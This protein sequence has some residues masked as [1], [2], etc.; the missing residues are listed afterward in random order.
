M[1]TIPR[2]L[3]A[4]SLIWIGLFRAEGQF[5]LLPM[6]SFGTAGWL[7]PN[8]VN[9]SSY[10]YL[11][12]NDTE[13]GMACG[14]SRLYLVSRN[15]GNFVRILDGQSGT[16]LGSLNLGTGMVSGGTFDVNAIAVADDGAIYVANLAIGPSAF[17]VYRWANDQPTTTPILVYNGVP[18]AGARLGDSLAVIG[19]GTS[20]LLAGGFNSAPAVSGNNG[21]AIIDPTAESALAVVFS[22]S[23]PAAGDFR[24]GITFLDS[25]HVLGTQGGS[26]LYSSFSGTNGTLLASPGLTSADERPLAFTTME[27]F[28][29]LAALSTTDNHVSLYELSD[30]TQPA[31]V[32]QANATSGSLPAD[33]HNT[34]AIAWSKTSGNTAIL[35]ALASDHGIEAFTVSAPAPLPVTITNQPQS[36]TVTELAPATFTV[37]AAGVPP[38]TYQWF[39]SDSRIL[40]ATNSVYTLASASSGDDGARFKVVAQNQIGNTTYTATSSVAVLTVELNTNGASYAL[41]SVGTPAFP[42]NQTVVSGGYDVTAGGTDFGG[43]SDQGV[44]SFQTR[45]GNFDV[46]A[47]LAGVS[48]SDVFAKAGL[49]AR[50]SLQPGSAFAGALATPSMVGAFFEWRPTLNGSSQSSGQLPVNY[51][52]TWLRLKRSGN[53]FTGYGSFDGQTW[54]QLGTANITM[55]NQVFLGLAVSSHNVG[56]S[57]TAQFRDLTESPSGTVEL[58]S[59]PYEPLGPCSRRTPIVVSELMY[60]PGPG[61][62]GQKLEFIELYNSS[63]WWE[64]IGGY[65]LNGDIL[66]TLPAGTVIPG[67]GFLVIT[68]TPAAL[69]AFYGIT[70]VLGPSLKADKP[71]G[72]IQ[73]RDEQGAVLLEFTYG[74]TLPWSPGANGTG[75]SLVLARPSYGEADPRAWAASESIGGSPG[76]AETFQPSPLRNVLI[77]EFLAHPGPASPGFVELYNHSPS[78]VDLSGCLLTDGQPNHQFTVPTNSIAGPG[79]FLDFTSAQMGF[80]LDP[81]GGVLFLLTPNGLQI[82]DSISYEAQGLNISS[83][84]RPDGAKEVY[85]LESPTPGTANSDILIGDIVLNEILYKPISGNDDD[86]F[87]ELYNQGTNRV[88]LNGWAF[89]AGIQFTFPPQT[90]V[91]PGAYLVVARN[92]ANLLSHYPQLSS[93]NTIGNFSG[94]LPHG[95]GR[96][97]LARPETS[98]STNDTGLVSTNWNMVVEDEV[99]YGVGGRWGQ[100]AH[101]GGSSLELINP[102]T[103]HRLPG[104][105]ADSDESSKSSWSTIEYSGPLDNGSNFSSSI[106]LVQ[107]GLLDVGECLIDKVEVRNATT[108]ANYLSNPDFENGLT[109]WTPQGDHIRSSL[110][111]TLG[112]Y[113]SSQCLHVRASDGIWTLFNSVQGTLTNTSL[114]SGQLVTLRLQGRWLHGS[115]EVLMRLHGNWLEATGALPIPNNLGT[116]GLPNSRSLD[117]PGPAIYEVQHSPAVPAASQPVLVTARID[118]RLGVQPTLLYRV[119]AGVSPAPSYKTVAMRDD[120]TAGDVLAGDGV[121]SALIPAQAAGKVVAFLVRA[122]NSFG[123]ATVF[124]EVLDDN[125]G[126]PRECV[127]GFGDPSPFGSFD[128]EHVWMTQNWLRRWASLGGLS[129]ESHD[130]TFVDGHSGRIIYNW[131]GRPAGSPYHQY[132]GSPDGT[133]GGEHWTMPE[134]DRFLGATSFNKQHVPGNGPLDD[135]TLQREQTSFWMARQLGVPW[136]YRRYFVLYVNG[137]R[138]GPLMEDTQV[139]GA[140]Q[141]KELWPNDSNG[142]LYKNNSWFEGAPTLDGGGYMNFQMPTWCLLGRFITAVDGVPGQYKLGRYRWMYWVRQYPDSANNFTNVFALITAANRSTADPAFASTLNSLVD[143]EEFMRMS[144]LEHATGDWDSWFTQNQWNMF[145]Y[146]PTLG[147]WTAL[148]WDWNI[149]LGGGTSTWPSDGSQLFNV[150]SNDPVMA[151]FQNFPEYHRALLRGFKEIAERAMNNQFVDPILDKKYQAFVA[152]GLTTSGQFGLQVRDPGASGG[153]KSWISAMHTSLLRTLTNQ[154]VASLTFSVDGPPEYSV[155]LTQVVLTGTAP[156]EVKTL[157]VNNAL[158]PVTWTSVKTWRLTVP[159][160]Q[161]TN[162]FLVQGLDLRGGALTNMTTSL[163][164]LNTNAMTVTLSPIVINE[165]MAGNNVL[166]DPSDTVPHDWFELYNPNDALVDLSGYYLT[167]NLANKTKWQ[168]PPRTSIGPFGFLLV[169]ADGGL[170]GSDH[171]LHANFRLAKSGATIALLS[172]VGDLV[173]SVSFGPQFSNVSQGRWPDG[174]PEVVFLTAPSP[175]A[176]NIL[177]QAIT[178]T[179][180]GLT[181][182]GQMSFTWSTS[183]GASYRVETKSDL[184]QTSWEP[185]AEFIASGSALTFTETTAA[186]DIQRYYR[187]MQP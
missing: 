6:K 46:A 32:A 180:V 62:G 182:S 91:A 33:T 31:L 53:S 29:L 10:P 106:D 149:T 96:L 113:Q 52:N 133:V 146:K 43:T 184:N 89:T 69:M 2:A 76:T 45:A 61:L 130:G 169:W 187:V 93:A 148:K 50:A 119:D 13:R 8:G 102:R 160:S 34:G 164:I 40:D 120:G 42:G 19:Q 126:L 122:Q 79:G 75:H 5:S 78:A 44:L 82:L 66:Y 139:P 163:S 155:G 175:A 112:G 47:R 144:A 26:L 87:V 68:P 141:I 157:S 67:G 55:P 63:P 49:M 3:L 132:T 137:N 100:W 14:N 135:D 179:E 129:N 80:A 36:L 99:T 168:I 15:G 28:P 77:N 185:L 152:N 16:D 57:T 114:R 170:V 41:S 25:S 111:T 97:A 11:T 108:G 128:H 107:L 20:T 85:P 154:G 178:L 167:D 171:D 64:D 156:L 94:K 142:F 109:G 183:P 165:W 131:A 35:Y 18:L 104:N 162:D 51:P 81:S 159:L 37:G 118:D 136:L 70:N 38:P 181:Q 65:R 105:W 123:G 92:A 174:G 24:L 173:D 12:T 172:P 27:G 166:T 54:T 73:L 71:T 60:N 21:Y 145:I 153:L 90:T 1:M 127:V 22:G 9:G 17:R 143:T 186:A 86:Q 147:Q 98:L 124:P 117:L 161:A 72:L 4:A 150:G 176:P 121:Y 151:K 23:P 101:G 134:D 83:G 74:T 138:H 158:L 84:R 95:G 7:A 115:P 30:P 116:P 59:S 58:M 48:P 103:N 39:R 140:D 56:I 88:D 125:S 177:A 110:E